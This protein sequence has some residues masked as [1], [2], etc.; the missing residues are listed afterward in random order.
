VRGIPTGANEDNEDEHETWV[1]KI[2]AIKHD[3]VQLQWLWRPEDL[4][5]EDRKKLERERDR[6]LEQ[7]PNSDR[8]PEKLIMTSCESQRD[9]V[10]KQHILESVSMGEG[11]KAPFA[12]YYWTHMYF[13]DSHRMFGPFNVDR[14]R[15]I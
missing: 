5:Q 6:K 11:Q 13:P 10:P 4:R 2:L 9:W 8:H 14:T 1:G 7:K 12:T 3:E 15:I